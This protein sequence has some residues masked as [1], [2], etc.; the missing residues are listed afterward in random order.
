MTGSPFNYLLLFVHMFELHL[1]DS[2]T[3]DLW[4]V[5]NKEYKYF[6]SSSSSITDHRIGGDQVDLREDLSSDQGGTGSASGSS[7]SASAYRGRFELMMHQVNVFLWTLNVAF[8]IHL[9]ISF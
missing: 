7:M 9:W 6:S 2:V 1:Y 5:I 3:Q 8:F 4:S